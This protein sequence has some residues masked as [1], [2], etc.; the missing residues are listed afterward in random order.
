MS[1][2]NMAKMPLPGDI[3]ARDSGDRIRIEQLNSPVII[4]NKLNIVFSELTNDGETFEVSLEHWF[5]LA[6]NY[7]LVTRGSEYRL[8]PKKVFM[9]FAKG[10]ALASRTV[11]QL[12]R[13]QSYETREERYVPKIK[14][15]RN[16][17]KVII[18]IAQG[19]Y[20]DT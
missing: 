11:D 6:E 15:F 16:I 20:L 3:Y 4:N 14:F 19:V 13:N 5:T 2:T 1:N 18:A 9:E 12:S 17:S 10:F 7:Y 8:T